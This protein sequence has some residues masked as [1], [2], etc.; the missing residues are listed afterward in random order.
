MEFFPANEEVSSSVLKGTSGWVWAAL[1]EELL[2][3]VPFETV[4]PK[5]LDLPS[6]DVVTSCLEEVVR[7]WKVVVLT[8]FEAALMQVKPHHRGEVCAAEQRRLLPL[9]LVLLSLLLE[10]GTHP[11]LH[12]VVEIDLDCLEIKE[13]S[14]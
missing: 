10:S 1:K 8:S 4:V 9:L 7:S 6:V 3:V 14:Q 12:S 5:L 2:R 13:T 11:S